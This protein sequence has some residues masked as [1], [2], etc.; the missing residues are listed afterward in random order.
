MNLYGPDSKTSLIASDDDS[1]V[2]LNARIVAGLVPGRYYVQ[3]RHYD[4]D[5]T[6][7]GTGSYTVKVRRP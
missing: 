5:T 3:V 7:G 6:A 1:G 4:S 2:D